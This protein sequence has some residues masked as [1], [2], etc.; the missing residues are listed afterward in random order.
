MDGG[1]EVL[2][3]MAE[4]EAQGQQRIDARRPGDMGVVWAKWRSWEIRSGRGGGVGG[5]GLEIVEGDNVDE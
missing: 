3:R 5:G 1:S 4:I 2:V